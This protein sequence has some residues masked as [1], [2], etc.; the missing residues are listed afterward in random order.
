MP[1]TPRQ[2]V[3]AYLSALADDDMKRLCAVTTGTIEGLGRSDDACGEPE[4]P[5]L[6]RI[7][8][9]A[10]NAVAELTPEAV[11]VSAQATEAEVSVSWGPEH[12]PGV[13]VPGRDRP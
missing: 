9:D 7:C 11:T 5:R 12:P 6:R 13:R 4:Q 1:W 3:A 2:A 10:R 8:E